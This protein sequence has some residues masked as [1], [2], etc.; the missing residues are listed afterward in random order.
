MEEHNEKKAI[1]YGIWGTVFLSI[2]GTLGGRIPFVGI[3]IYLAAVLFFI[4]AGKRGFIYTL[5]FIIAAYVFVSFGSSFSGAISDILGP[6]LSA[7]VMGELMR[8]HRRQGERLG[9]G[10]LTAALCN[11]ASMISIQLAEGVSILEELRKTVKSALTAAVDAEEITIYGAQMMSRAYETVLQLIPAIMIITV[12]LGTV[13]IYFVGCAVMAKKGEQIQGYVPFRFFSFSR[14]IIFG[15]LLMYLFGF[16]AGLTGFISTDVLLFNISVMVWFLFTIQG[17]ATLVY[18]CNA[19]RF[20]K[21][22]LSVLLGL[23]FI[24]IIGT[25]PLFFIG[26]LDVIVDIR[27]RIDAKRG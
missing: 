3:L 21:S 1:K 9:K 16:L 7:A 26:V 20:P 4:C 25:L 22:V 11:L 12:V 5:P 24:S 2:I 23:L 27:K 14:S 17:T 19:A 18:L 6:G 13:F 15:C 10:I 8:L